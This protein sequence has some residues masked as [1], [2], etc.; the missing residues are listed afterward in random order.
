MQTAFHGLFSAARRSCTGGRCAG[1]RWP[2]PLLPCAAGLL[3]L[4]A[5]ALV[6]LADRDPARAMALAGFAALAV[7]PLF[8]AAGG[9][10][11][12]FVHPFAFSLFSAA[13]WPRAARPA[14][15]ACVFWWAI[16]LAFEAAQAPPLR[17]ALTAT[18]HPGP[19]AVAPVRWLLRFAQQ[20]RF[21][22]AD[23]LAVS[24]GAL[25]AAGLLHF[26]NRMEKPHA[27]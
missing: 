2:A 27:H 11:P 19:D 1:A 15:G 21:D 25:A 16:N 4:A 7:G 17:D 9:W 24:A 20:G 3:A 26:L 18:L 23:V 5:G 10:L 14:Y 13:A 6:Y 8:G 12:S 22:P